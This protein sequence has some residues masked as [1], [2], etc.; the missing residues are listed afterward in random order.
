MAASAN[1][2]THVKASRRKLGLGPGDA[3]KLAGVSRPTWDAWEKGTIPTDKNW[4]AVER[5]LEW[6]RGS[7]EAVLAG[8]EPKPVHDHSP[9]DDLAA[10]LDELGIDPRKWRRIPQSTRDAIATAYR[11]DRERLAREAKAQRPQ[12][13]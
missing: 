13:A 2:A 7:V 3:A 4:T 11:V 12:G 1:F 6:E 9:P 10:M 5:A 8:G